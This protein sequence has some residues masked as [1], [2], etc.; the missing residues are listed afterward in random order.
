NRRA[1]AMSTNPSP[2]GRTRIGCRTPCRR[3]LAVS[4]SRLASEN[5]RRGLVGDSWITFVSS[6]LNSRIATPRVKWR[7][8]R[9]GAGVGRAMSH[10]RCGTGGPGSARQELEWEE[11]AVR[12]LGPH[13]FRPRLV[14]RGEETAGGAVEGEAAVLPGRALTESCQS[15]H[16]APHGPGIRLVLLR[17]A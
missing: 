7:R 10:S 2:F 6:C 15:L 14:D 8:G 11:G 5:D 13:G 4:S 16:I 1:P 3:T 17:E 9:W 12:T